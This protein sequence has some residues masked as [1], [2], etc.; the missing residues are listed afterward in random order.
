MK[1][2]PP[3]PLPLLLRAVGE[4]LY[5]APRYSVSIHG[6]RMAITQRQLASCTDPG[7][8][9]GETDRQAPEIG[10]IVNEK[11]DFFRLRYSIFRISLLAGKA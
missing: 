5:E 8:R 3:H 1:Y 11:E 10:F 6:R 7:S 9:G 4:G 2:W